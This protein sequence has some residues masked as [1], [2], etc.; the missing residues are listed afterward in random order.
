MDDGLLDV[1]YIMNPSTDTV[2]KL[3]MGLEK[4]CQLE[5]A[6]GRFR[7]AWLKVDCPE[8]LQVCIAI[9]AQMS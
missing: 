7:C 1:S 4:D 9:C 5:G 3:I 2:R 8:G 6:T